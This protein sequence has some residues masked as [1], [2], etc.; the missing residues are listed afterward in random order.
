[1]TPKACLRCDWEGEAKEPTCLNCGARPLYLIGDPP[2]DEHT[3]IPTSNRPEEQIQEPMSTA[4]IASSS[5]RHPQTDPPPAPAQA[6]E[7]SSRRGRSAVAFVLM[8]VVLTF[9]VGSSLTASEERSGPRATANATGPGRPIE[10]VSV[11]RSADPLPAGIRLSESLGVGRHSNTVDGIPFSFRV[12]TRDWE[13]HGNYISK[14]TAGSSQTAEAIIYWT[15]FPYRAD[16]EI[17]TCGQWWGSPVGRVADFAAAAAHQ[18]GTELVSGPSNVA[19]GGRPAKHVVFTVR[20]DVDC[21]GG[22]F[23]SWQN[24]NGGAFW[25]STNVGDTIRVWLVELGRKRLLYMEADTHQNAG[26]DLEQ[27]IQQ[28][29]GSIRFGIGF[30]GLPPQGAAPSTPDD[31]ELVLSFDGSAQGVPRSQVFVYADGRLIWRQVTK[32]RSTGFLERDLTPQGVELL[33]SEITSSGLFGDE[34]D[35]AARGPFDATPGS[36]LERLVPRLTHPEAWLPASAWEGQEIVTYVPSRYLVC[37][38]GPP[39][40]RERIVDRLSALGI[41]LFFDPD[42]CS[43]ATVAEARATADDL[44]HA[45][46]ERSGAEKTLAYQLE[47]EAFTFRF[48][49]Y[50]PHGQ[51]A[52]TIG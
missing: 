3:R 51:V 30:V 10:S 43:N 13:D 26:S 37:Y 46:L 23:Y 4:V 14:S 21:S 44:K 33:R 40:R 17:D 39:Y 50:L 11:P 15:S 38:E 27:D 20:E 31:G 12:P 6:A 1:M 18:Y 47:G 5:I 45:G 42:G 28:I 36:A 48:E 32:Q 9:I 7:S 2:P 19:L 49:P 34:L 41:N 25:T 24:D 52:A 16:G 35:L 8:A 22:F 29:V